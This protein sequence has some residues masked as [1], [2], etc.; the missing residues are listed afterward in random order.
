M[1][2]TLTILALVL[3]ACGGSA[4]TDDP[5]P[6]STTTTT[7][8]APTTTTTATPA[9]GDTTT[10]TT[11]ATTTTA[12]TQVSGPAKLVIASID[13]ETGMFT[14]RNDGGESLD[15]TGYFACNRPNYVELPGRVLEPGA[16]TDISTGGLS[17][18]ADD[19]EL[20]IY[21]SQSFSSTSAIRAYV[22]WGSDGHG[23]TGTAV[24]AGVWTE[25]EFVDNQGA[26]IVS[27]GSDPISS[28]DWVV[29]AAP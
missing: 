15:L 12:A 4:G 1:T 24:D 22:Q 10:T 2:R 26:P 20:G 5:P 8:Q 25:G 28:A 27:S 14:L 6:S 29:G 13:F 19:G 11:Q 21:T 23:R 16:T 7:T 17:L 18:S 9:D 3:A